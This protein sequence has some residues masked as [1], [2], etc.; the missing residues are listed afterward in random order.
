MTFTDTLAHCAGCQTREAQ[1]TALSAEVERL[2][3]VM[4]DKPGV[5]TIAYQDGDHQRLARAA[6]AALAAAAA[7][8]ARADKLREALTVARTY[9]KDAYDNAGG[10]FPDAVWQDLQKIDAAFKETTNG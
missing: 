6:F 1:I 2:R 7:A 8:E 3:K 9:I 5:V 4:V 10:D